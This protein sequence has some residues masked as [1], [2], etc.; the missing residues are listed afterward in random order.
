VLGQGKKVFPDGAKPSALRLL[1]PP[2]TG[3][4][5]VVQLRYGPTGSAPTTGDMSQPDRGV[6]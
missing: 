2:L 1:E 6:K 5:G 3:S 4:S